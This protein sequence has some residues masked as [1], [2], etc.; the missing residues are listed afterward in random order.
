MERY[1]IITSIEDMGPYVSKLILHMPCEVRCAEISEQ[2]FNIYVERR[3]IV[4]GEVIVSKSFV[5]GEESICKGY[6]KALAVYPCDAAGNKKA[7][8]NL[9][10]IELAEEALGK[11]IEGDVLQG[12][13]MIMT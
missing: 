7:V 5:T 3:D 8:S 12:R 4:T 13:F 10:A 9:A 11:R 2:S 1:Q 6:Q